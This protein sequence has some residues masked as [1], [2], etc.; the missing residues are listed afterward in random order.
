MPN[1]ISNNKAHKN[2]RV[3]ELSEKLDL[4]TLIE[5]L[6]PESKML[7][8]RV[9]NYI[10]Q[11]LCDFFEQKLLANK[12]VL[13]EK[14]SFAPNTDVTKI[15][16]TFTEACIDSSTLD[17]YFEQASKTEAFLKDFFSPYLNPIDK[18]RLELDEMWLQGSIVPLM[19][20]QKM[21]SGFIRKIGIDN[22]IPL[23][24][25][26][27]M[28]DC[29][30]KPDFNLTTE[31]VSN[32]YLSISPNNGCGELQIYD[33]SPGYKNDLNKVYDSRREGEAN[34]LP[35]HLEKL[36]SKSSITL[37]PKIG[38]LILFKGNLV[39]QV[40]KVIDK[41]R[42]TSCFHIGYTNNQEPLRCWI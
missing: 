21:M 35:S 17:T 11:E 42:I 32:V 36:S 9:S 10:S 20:G 4:H 33:Y 40:H 31:L 27:L 26:D 13:F 28:Q 38:D 19:Y 29:R 12:S 37:K 23:H 24:Q 41:E 5:F 1:T 7:A 6:Q 22:E 2:N 3:Y 30:Q 25:D 18:L 8:I 15:G 16:K 14:Y 39:H 34:L